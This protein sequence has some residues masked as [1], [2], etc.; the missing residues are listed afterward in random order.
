MI[1]RLVV[2]NL[3]YSRLTNLCP[4]LKM[5]ETS[6]WTFQKNM[7]NILHL[8]NVNFKGDLFFAVDISFW[9]SY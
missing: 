4:L 3:A 6:S 1:E 2:E 8:K 5:L 7:S 9:I